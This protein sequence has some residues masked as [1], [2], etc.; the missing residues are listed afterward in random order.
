MSKVSALMKIC[1][2]KNLP[3]EVED[4]LFEYFGKPFKMF[5]YLASAYYPTNAPLLFIKALKLNTK[6]NSPFSKNNLLITKLADRE[7]VLLNSDD[8]QDEYDDYRMSYTLLETALRECYVTDELVKSCIHFG[9]F[10]DT[11]DFYIKFSRISIFI[12]NVATVGSDYNN[13]V[14]ILKNCDSRYALI[15]I[16]NDGLEYDMLRYTNISIY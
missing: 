3:T 12:K 5:K 13:Y 15:D 11:N 9:Q 7:L 16:I 8:Y 14:E 2:V 10:Q 1:K 6:N 4:L